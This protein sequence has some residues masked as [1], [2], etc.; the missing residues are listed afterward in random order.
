[1]SQD[2][3]IITVSQINSYI[4]AVLEQD[5]NLRRLYVS[6]EISNFKRHYPSGHLYFSLKTHQCVLSIWVAMIYSSDGPKKRLTK[7][8]TGKCPLLKGFGS[9]SEQG[10]IGSFTTWAPIL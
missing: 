5:E 2:Q 8:Y 7:K 6:G 3:Q 10:G 1:M 9:I 4:K